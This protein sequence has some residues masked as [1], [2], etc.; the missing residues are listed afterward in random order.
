MN[1]IEFDYENKEYNEII[2]KIMLHTID[3][4][5]LESYFNKGLKKDEKEKVLFE[6][7]NLDFSI[8]SIEEVISET[9]NYFK[10]YL[11]PNFAEYLID[12]LIGYREIAP[13]MKSD[14]YE[15]IMINDYNKVFVIS[16][17]NVYYKTNITFD[18]RT[19]N[20]FLEYVKKS[21]NGSFNKRKFIDGI[22][23]DNSR[24]NIVS[25]EIA[26]FNVIT[27][28]KFLA[29][30]LTII[31][32]IKNNTINYEIGAYLWTVIDGFNLKPANLFIC[33]G[34]STGKTTLLNV[35]LNFVN[36]KERVIC[37]ED[38]K[39]INNSI[40]DN[41]VSLISDISDPDS[42]YNITLNILR[43][44]PDRIVIG[45]TRGKEAKAL[46]M[47]MDTGHQ[48]CISTIHANNSGDLIN[49]LLSEPMNIEESYIKLL[50]IIVTFDRKFVG[51]KM[52]RYVSQISEISRIGNI[53][54]NHIYSNENMEYD[55]SVNFMSSHF[56]EK[57]CTYVGISK[58]EVQIVIEN[59]IKILKSMVERDLKDSYEIRKILVDPKFGYKE[60]L[61]K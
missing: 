32:L 11:D 41:S 45:E 53:T 61:H 40:F 44:R 48:G 8:I 10:N 39:E 47:A 25:K 17:K 49:K 28:R 13:I 36:H 55:A 6:I 20:V 43:M 27:I 42:L 21:I 58:L 60:L 51:E 12:Y 34:T 46:F 29:K 35:L 31:D 26:R 18:K 50:D 24:I 15:E 7:K 30:P 52:Y 23:P 3:I 16:R 37:V 19:F 2:Y 57:L 5:D 38:T 1:E 4:S 33:G 14:D 54:L 9:K 56:L 59:R 22:L